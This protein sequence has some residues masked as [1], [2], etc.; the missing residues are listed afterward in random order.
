MTPQRLSLPLSVCL[1][2]PTR[3]PRP[4]APT[5]YK[6]VRKG[7]PAADRAHPVTRTRRAEPRSTISQPG[8]RRQLVAVANLPPLLSRPVLR[9][10][11][12][13]SHRQNGGAAHLF[14]P[15]VCLSTSESKSLLGD[16]ERAYSAPPDLLRSH[17]SSFFS[18]PPS[19]IILIPA[20]WRAGFYLPPACFP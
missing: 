19:L 18:L 3:P 2:P 17:S 16:D 1:P 11:L 14:F 9:S 7:R 4:P 13:T 10:D 20:R 15:P 8:Q 12:Q 6:V 5:R